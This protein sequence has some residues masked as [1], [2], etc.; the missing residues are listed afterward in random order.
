LSGDKGYD[1][2]KNKKTLYDEHDIKPVIDTRQFRKDEDTRPVYPERADVFVYNEKGEVFCH[3][4]SSRRD[5]QQVR[6]LAFV[7]FEKDRK[8]LKYRCPAAY[9]ELESPGRAAFE[10]DAKAGPYG[11]V[12]CIL[13]IKPKTFTVRKLV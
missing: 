12:V 8:T 7:G 10:V 2:E 11:R 13:H 3:C 6:Q 4:P 5:E 1:S 9:Y